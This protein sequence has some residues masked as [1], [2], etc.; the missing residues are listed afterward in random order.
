MCLTLVIQPNVTLLFNGVNSHEALGH[1]S[2]SYDTTECHSSMA[3]PAMRHW[4]T[5]L[6]LVIQTNV[7]LLFNGVTSHEELGHVSDSC[8]TTECHFALEWRH[9][10]RGTGTCV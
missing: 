7:T 6:T 1:V 9:Q 4:D 5:C 8:D 2:D 3:S 10:P